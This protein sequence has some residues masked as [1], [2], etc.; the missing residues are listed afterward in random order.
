MCTYL[1]VVGEGQGR[2]HRVPL[3]RELSCPEVAPRRLV[4]AAQLTVAM[5]Q[6][7]HRALPRF[8]RLRTRHDVVVV[9]KEGSKA[10]HKRRQKYGGGSVRLQQ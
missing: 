7:K 10:A 8:Q 2:V 3:G 5:A 6:V 9:G 1:E 4:E